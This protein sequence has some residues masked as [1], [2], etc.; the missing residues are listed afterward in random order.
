MDKVKANANTVFSAGLG[1]VRRQF[2][3]WLLRWNPWSK[4]ETNPSIRI[5]VVLFL[6]LM[7]R[8]NVF[9]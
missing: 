1:K 5:V 6:G 3:M 7:H 9:A 8:S 2:D 4:V